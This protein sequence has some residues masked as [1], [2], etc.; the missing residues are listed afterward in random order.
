LEAP[1]LELESAVSMPVKNAKGKAK[2]KSQAKRAKKECD[3]D[4]G[5]ASRKPR[6]KKCE[7]DVNRIAALRSRRTSVKTMVGHSVG[8]G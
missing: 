1:T 8:N 7:Q 5:D 4:P 3:G 2:A 6:H